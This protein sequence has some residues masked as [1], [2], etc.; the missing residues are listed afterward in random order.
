MSERHLR[1]Q[2][3]NLNLRRSYVAIDEAIEFIYHE[4]QHSGRLHGYKW[5][6]QKL[7]SA[8]IS[9]KKEDVRILLKFLDPEAVEFRMNWIMFCKCGMITKFGHQ[10]VVFQAEGLE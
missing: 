3:V 8:N 1:R 9:V 7:K 4:L 2:L 5:M 6:H 10:D